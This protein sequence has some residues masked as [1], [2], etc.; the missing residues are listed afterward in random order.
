[1]RT[2]RQGAER[3]EPA[4]TELEAA[5]SPTSTGRA[6]KLLPPA[7]PLEP[8]LDGEGLAAAEQRVARTRGVAGGAAAGRGRPGLRRGAGQFVWVGLFVGLGGG[9][10]ACS[11]FLARE[12]GGMP[13]SAETLAD[14]DFSGTHRK[15][16]DGESLEF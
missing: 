5:S 8:S 9:N 12:L 13:N 2:E 11:A 7:G 10:W 1:M 15:Q 14:T 4:A 6:Q 3:S 16:R